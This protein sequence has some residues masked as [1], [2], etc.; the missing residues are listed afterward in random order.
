MTALE[1]ALATPGLGWLLLA[2]AMSGLV[3]GFTG[4]GTALVF[5]PVAALVVPPF[6]V[7]TLLVVMDFI[8]PLPSLPRAFRDGSPR[9]LLRLCGGMA[10]GLPLGLW[11]LGHLPVEVFQWS[12]SLLALALLGLLIGGWRYRGPR[13][14]AVPFATGG[15]SGFL[16]GSTGIGG[17]PVI[18]FYMASGLP[19]AMMRG[20]F[21][22]YFVTT[23]I[24]MLV[25][26]GLMGHLSV[27]AIV[28]G[29]VMVPPFMLA[30]IAGAAMFR[31]EGETLYR[32][33]AYALIALAALAGLPVWS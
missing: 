6:W 10:V 27:T 9:E 4:F 33:V 30:S 32:R 12:V 11:V 29:L 20:N 25:A 5:V 14:G 13:G 24:A 22:I 19:A 1:A 21:L 31:P 26:L 18:L 28:L 2:A 8:G 23:S 16:G 17:P 7:L 3:R 15:V